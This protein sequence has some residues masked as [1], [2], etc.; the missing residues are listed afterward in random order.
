MIINIMSY[1]RRE[2]AEVNIIPDFSAGG[3]RYSNLRI[4]G[5]LWSNQTGSVI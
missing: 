3:S 2:S 5:I 1:T 4:V